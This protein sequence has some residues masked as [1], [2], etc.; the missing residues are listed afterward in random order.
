MICGLPTVVSIFRLQAP[1]GGRQ[2][3]AANQ[4]F[5]R[6]LRSCAAEK[7]TVQ[8]P[9]TRS[10]LTL[11]KPFGHTLKIR[12][13]RT[14]KNH[15]MYKTKASPTQGSFC[16]PINLNFLRRQRR[17]FSFFRCRKQRK[18]GTLNPLQRCFGNGYILPR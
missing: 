5:T 17:F 7:D 14:N 8:I 10:R 1:S 9:Q 6:L 16:L 3:S 2:R 15:R 4:I 12:A 18:F 13:C 11:F